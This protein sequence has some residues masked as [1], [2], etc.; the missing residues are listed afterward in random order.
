MIIQL[1]TFG[2]F[3]LILSTIF[4]PQVTRFGIS[5]G[6]I[7]KKNINLDIPAGKVRIGG[8]AI[9]LSQIITLNIAFFL[10]IMPLNLDMNVLFISTTS[11]IFLIGLIDDI[12]SLSALFRL[13]MQLFI[14]SL[15]YLY[16]I[17][18]DPES[19]ILLSDID[20]NFFNPYILSFIFTNIWLIGITNA[21][22][23]LDGLDGLASGFSISCAIVLG[24][25]NLINNNLYGFLLSVIILGSNAGFLKYN[26][27]PSRILMGD[28]GSNFNGF[29]LGLLAMI[30]F[31]IESI[32]SLTCMFI[33][34]L[35]PI[36]DM[37]KVIILRFLSGKNPLLGDNTHLHYNLINHGLSH[38]ESVL[39]M[40]FLFVLTSTLSYAL[41]KY[42]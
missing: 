5:K 15:V 33:L 39:I 38:K 36:Y 26:F 19:F 17:N 34:F 1:I 4:T 32:G 18:I 30:T 8:I 6:F 40:Y 12:L 10:L 22:N 42:F 16:G 25:V 11:L 14:G 24:L 13:I 21:I 2:I 7:D 20:Q 27:Y 41:Y 9:Y 29:Y 3:A 37:F 23:W 28:C 35:V 31:K